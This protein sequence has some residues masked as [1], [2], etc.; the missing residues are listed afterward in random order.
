VHFVR[1]A[2]T[3]LQ[4]EESARDNH[5]LASS[6]TKYSPI[7][8]FS[9]TNSSKNLS[10]NLSLIAFFLTLMFHKAVATYARNGEILPVYCKFTKVTFSGKKIANRLRFDRIMDMCLTFLAHPI[11][12]QYQKGN[13]T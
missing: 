6:F 12:Q 4:D 5:V 13:I 2:T 11:E 7:K 10:R 1:L 9:L 3:L 8:F